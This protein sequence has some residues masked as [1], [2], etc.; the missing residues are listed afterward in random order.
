MNHTSF[1]ST[2]P[3]VRLERGRLPEGLAA[4][5]AAERPR[6]H[7]RPEIGKSEDIVTGIQG[8]G[9]YLTQYRDRLKSFY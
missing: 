1:I 4:H 8:Q 6:A 5:L 2:L 7:V 3:H 9:H